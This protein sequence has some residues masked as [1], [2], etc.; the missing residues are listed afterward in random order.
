[1]L[2]E[3]GRLSLKLLWPDRGVGIGGRVVLLLRCEDL[4]AWRDDLR[5]CFRSATNHCVLFMAQP[6]WAGRLPT[7]PAVL[8]AYMPRISCT[9][10]VYDE[11]TEEYM[12]F[13]RAM[14]LVREVEEHQPQQQQHQGGGDSAAPPVPA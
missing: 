6:A 9:P 5:S 3:A 10:Q 14:E 1:M 4:V 13:D 12:T 7:Q 11:A 2:L 8:E